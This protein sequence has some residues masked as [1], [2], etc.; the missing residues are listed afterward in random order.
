MP[1]T[2]KDRPFLADLVG[3]I[4]LYQPKKE[5]EWLCI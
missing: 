2:A 5:K 4:H 3:V 1:E